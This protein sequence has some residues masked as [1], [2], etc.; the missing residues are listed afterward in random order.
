M[1]N[2]FISVTLLTLISLSSLYANDIENTIIPTKHSKTL[3]L[4][5]IAEIQPGLGTVM[6]EFGHRFYLTYYAAKAENWELAEY[7]IEELIEAQ[8]I[9]ETTRPKYALKLQAFESIYL[10]KLQNSIRKQDWKLFEKNYTQTTNACN[11][12]HK[13]NGHSYIQ[14]S[15]PKESP[16]Y[17]KMAL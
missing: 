7:E 4:S 11:A 16:K 13:E 12:C 9:A 15:L 10:K 1:K 6:M 14:Y 5:S 17:L 2:R 8:E 3:T